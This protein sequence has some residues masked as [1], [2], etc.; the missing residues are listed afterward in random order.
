MQYDNY[1]SDFR[2]QA[3]DRG[4]WYDQLLPGMKATVILEDEN[5]DEVTHTVPIKFEVCPTCD[6]RGKH[7]NPSVDCNGLSA[8]DFAEDPDFAEDYVSGRYDVSCYECGGRNVV[9]VCADEKV[10]ELLREKAE[11]DAY[12][13]SI[14]EAERR[15]GA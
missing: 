1:Y 15:M 12:F 3:R 11:E 14:Q 7:A 13:R 2:V 8:D 6:G 10:S 5:G 9:P 4:R